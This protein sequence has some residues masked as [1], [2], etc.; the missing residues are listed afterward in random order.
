MPQLG[1]SLTIVIL[2]TLDVS[3]TIVMFIKYRRQV[4]LSLSVTS[5]QVLYLRKGPDP[6]LEGALSVA[7]YY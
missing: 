2:M 5:S 1:A 7:K 4:G 3:F 6:T